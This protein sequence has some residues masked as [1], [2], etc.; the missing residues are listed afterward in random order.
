MQSRL[1][2]S[3][4]TVSSVTLHYIAAAVLTLCCS[5]LS[6]AITVFDPQKVN[7]KF[8]TAS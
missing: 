7:K 6:Q 2:L 1:G 5:R 3:G 4:G 8:L